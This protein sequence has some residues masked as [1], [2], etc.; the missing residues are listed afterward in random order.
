MVGASSED[1]VIWGEKIFVFSLSLP[2]SAGCDRWLMSCGG[3]RY[4][5]NWDTEREYLQEILVKNKLASL[6]EEIK[7]AKESTWINCAMAP[8]CFS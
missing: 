3:T 2:L 5:Q 8:I 1:I 7:R 4:R 6:L